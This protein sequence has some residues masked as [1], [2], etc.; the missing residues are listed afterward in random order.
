MYQPRG[1][2]QEIGVEIGAAE[3]GALVVNVDG[4]DYGEGVTSR[5]KYRRYGGCHISL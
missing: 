2:G 5:R 1:L 3:M 4:V